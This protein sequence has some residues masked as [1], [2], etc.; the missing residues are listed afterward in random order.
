M[1]ILSSLQAHKHAEY[2]AK[3]PCKHTVSS[4]YVC[5]EWAVGIYM[6][7]MHGHYAASGP[8]P[9]F[10]EGGLYMHNAIVIISVVCLQWM[11]DVPCY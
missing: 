3:V 5:G 11:Y 10:L 7:Y 4:Q 8:V 9:G 1:L 6:S 2:S